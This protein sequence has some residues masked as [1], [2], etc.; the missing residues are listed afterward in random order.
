LGFETEKQFG[1]E[2]N[3]IKPAEKRL[4]QSMNV[5]RKFEELSKN[6]I[7]V[8]PNEI[9]IDSPKANENQIVKS[10]AGNIT[11]KSH[12][13]DS[14]SKNTNSQSN[15]EQ[16]P[17]EKKN[18][19]NNELKTGLISHERHFD[20]VNDLK[21]SLSRI[22]EDGKNNSI[23]L[24]KT[25]KAFELH[26]EL[27]NILASRESRNVTL[28]LSPEQ[29]GKVNVI[30]DIADNVMNT[31]ISVESESVK[32]MVQNS[33]TEL[34]NSLSESGIQLMGFSVGMA[35]GEE[36]GNSKFAGKAKKKNYSVDEN[37]I[38]EENIEEE[39][40]KKLGYNTY[41]YIM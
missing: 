40:S 37:L 4:N 35:S 25:V 16:N 38:I 24:A 13:A 33:A 29:L 22:T 12:V 21:E 8:T 20:F 32:Q 41:D 7:N 23:E 11:S 18:T 6:F 36:K 10:D 5:E 2:I 17:T 9:S 28:R 30:I 1:D 31:K 39:K 26:N 3:N 14:D 34:R 27:K 15:S 19:L